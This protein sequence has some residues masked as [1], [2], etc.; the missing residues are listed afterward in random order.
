[1]KQC[2]LSG[3]TVSEVGDETDAADRFE[4]VF[5]LEFF[6]NQDGI[7]LAATFEERNHR[8]EDAAVRGD[9]EIFG[10]QLF[11]CL[12]DQAVVEKMPPRIARSASELFGRERSSDCSRMGSGVA[13]N[14]I[15]N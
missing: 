4:R 15:H 12:A 14:E 3:Q 8:D 1:V 5:F 2:W 11:D 6:A 10:P 13:M 9:V 7:D